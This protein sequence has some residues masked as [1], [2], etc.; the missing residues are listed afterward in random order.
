MSK[1]E[2]KFESPS[3]LIFDS[4][5]WT[6]EESGLGTW[7]LAHLCSWRYVKID[8]IEL[9]RRLV[10]LFITFEREKFTDSQERSIKKLSWY[11]TFNKTALKTICFTPFNHTLHDDARG[12]EKK[13]PGNKLKLIIMTHAYKTTSCKLSINDQE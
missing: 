13:I 8:Q 2:R 12:K 7:E 1:V 3:P 6:F 11:K 4:A 9:V 10:I 5:S